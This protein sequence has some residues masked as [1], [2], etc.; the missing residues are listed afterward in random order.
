MVSDFGNSKFISSKL[1]YVSFHFDIRER[2]FSNSPSENSLFDNAFKTMF[3]IELIWLSIK[4]FCF[5]CFWIFLKRCFSINFR[6]IE[7]LPK[8]KFNPCKIC[9]EMLPMIS[10]K[11]D[12]KPTL[13]K[14]IQN[15]IS[16]KQTWQKLITRWYFFTTDSCLIFSKWI[17]FSISCICWSLYKWP[18]D[19]YSLLL[20]E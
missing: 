13:N 5:S 19:P 9:P 7:I 15:W 8:S 20:N 3:R 17:S 11:L 14:N 4:V 10:W 12:K 6:K 1:L 16:M 18:K 2:I